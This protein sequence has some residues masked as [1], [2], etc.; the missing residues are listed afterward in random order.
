MLSLKII[1]P[2]KHQ[3]TLACDGQNP[4]ISLRETHLVLDST[5]HHWDFFSFVLIQ[6]CKN[7][8]RQT[9]KK[10]Q[11]TKRQ[12][13]IPQHQA[14]GKSGIPTRLLLIF[15]VFNGK[16]PHKDTNSFKAASQ[17]RKKMRGRDSVSVLHY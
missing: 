7:T 1:F 8:K 16:V 6:D 15:T 4:F 9:E 14:W 12:K 5:G 13:E 10:K 2:K 11:K 17:P 3:E